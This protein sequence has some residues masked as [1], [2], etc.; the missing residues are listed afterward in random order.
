MR[1]ARV[2]H[3]RSD[4]SIEGSVSLLWTFRLLVWYLA[5]IVSCMCAWVIFKAIPTIHHSL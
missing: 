3:L 1:A 5:T 2:A 4:Q